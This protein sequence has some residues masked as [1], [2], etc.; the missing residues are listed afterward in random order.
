[1]NPVY[2]C[3]LVSTY[4][5]GHQPFGLAE[6]A[7]MLRERGAAVRTV[8]LA[9]ECLDEAYSEGLASSRFTSKCTPLPAWRRE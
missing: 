9:V 1:V 4:E 8:D 5:L 2:T 7:A 3:L 6:P